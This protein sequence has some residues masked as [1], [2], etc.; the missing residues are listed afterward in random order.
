MSTDTFAGR[1]LAKQVA[2]TSSAIEIVVDLFI[3][4]EEAQ[5]AQLKLSNGLM[6]L[7]VA[8]IL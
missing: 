4:V 5:F 6:P 1:R 3:S 2:R 8:W 7:M